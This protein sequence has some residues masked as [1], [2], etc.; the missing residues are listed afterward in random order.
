MTEQVLG[1]MDVCRPFRTLE[2]HVVAL[3]KA[4]PWLPAQGD[5]VRRV[6]ENLVSRGLL[7]SD[8]DYL[9][10]LRRQDITS[11]AADF[12]GFYIRACDRP[13]QLRRLLA[14]LLDYERSYAPGHRYTVLDD[15]RDSDHAR[16]NRRLLAEFGAE[17]GVHVHYVGHESWGRMCNLLAP[18]ATD[19]V[20]FDWLLRRA[21][22]QRAHSGGLAMNLIAL[23]TAERRYALLDDDFVFP[24]RLHPE[25]DPRVDLGPAGPVPARFFQ[26][27]DA[28]LA[29]GRDPE[30]DP[31]QMHLDACG[32]R[33]SD[34]LGQH[35][36][37]QLG[38]EQLRG[39][40]PSHLP[41]LQ[42]GRRIV[43]TVNGHRGHS[44]TS[45]SG[46][47][48]LLDPTSRETLWADRAQ[49]LRHIDSPNLWFGPTRATL[50]AH[51]NFTP[52]MVDGSS[53]LPA[54]APAGRGEDQLFAGLC[55][56]LDP[57]SLTL[58]LP[59]SI[60]HWQEQERKR[61]ET[62]RQAF[63]PS[64]NAYLADL[65]MD[66]AGD[67]HATDPALRL[68]G[69]AARVR[70]LAAASDS[71]V[72]GLLREHLAYARSTLVGQLQAV[73]HASKSAPVY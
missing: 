54:T 19:R 53:L 51:G 8:A 1:A 29:S 17:A 25:Q 45:S 58:N 49:Y 66:S 30:G 40:A 34:V 9:A 46:W 33:L 47:L 5:A 63:A 31:L 26:N 11:N 4:I 6:L 3:R 21:P 15:S 57:D 38:I 10:R 28:A 64:F 52:F 42:A 14:S 37:L 65:A 35:P 7:L 2:Q 67:F 55:R 24:L 22:E 70:D 71:A 36:Q 50:H 72:L 56:L 16:E 48:F 23:L 73:M 12:A 59:T 39:V 44:G 13:T 20:A 27:L 32:M 62:L 18:A 43:A 41:H 69:F 60:G 68:R 61:G